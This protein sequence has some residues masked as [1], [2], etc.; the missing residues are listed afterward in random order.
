[1]GSGKT[2]RIDANIPEH[3]YSQL[4]EEAAEAFRTI[5]GQLCFVLNQHFLNKGASL[6]SGYTAGVSVRSQGKE[7]QT[8]FKYNRQ[9][10]SSTLSTISSIQPQRLFLLS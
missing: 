9:T 10:P 7:V 8:E 1:M 2:R 4:E 5:P 3:L 6:I